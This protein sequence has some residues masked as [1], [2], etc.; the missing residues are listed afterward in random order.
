MW[1][2]P[3]A[4]LLAALGTLPTP[5]P[6][7]MHFWLLISKHLR[8]F[9]LLNICSSH[10]QNTHLS[11]ALLL[12]GGQMWTGGTRRPCARLRIPLLPCKQAHLRCKKVPDC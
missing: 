12:P 7:H 11:G 5:S 9:S 4:A 8:H 6:R 1:L 10:I 2:C 3:M